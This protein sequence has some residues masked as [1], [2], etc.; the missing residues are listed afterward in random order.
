L[1]AAAKLV[2]L[3]HWSRFGMA[4]TRTTEHYEIAILV[5]MAD[6]Q[7]FADNIPDR[8][9]PKLASSLFDCHL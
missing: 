5:E 6:N 7:N 3:F 2:A 9:L 8:R 1:L 4:T